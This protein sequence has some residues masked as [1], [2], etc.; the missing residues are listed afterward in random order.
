MAGAGA[1]GEAVDADVGVSAGASVAV[2]TVVD[3]AVG[4]GAEVAIGG[5]GVAVGAGASVAGGTRGGVA[6]GSG[7]QVVTV[8]VS[9]GAS[10][11]VNAVTGVDVAVGWSADLSE[12]KGCSSEDEHPIKTKTKNNKPVPDIR[13]TS[14][15]IPIH[16]L[17]Q[18]DAAR[19][20]LTLLQA[21]PFPRV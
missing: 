2:G 20:F 10:A 16:L 19:I 7:S 9:V 8:G 13:V 1:R 21:P 5:V 14:I 6:V 11:S 15:G 4:S 12:I 18:T 3:V 17:G